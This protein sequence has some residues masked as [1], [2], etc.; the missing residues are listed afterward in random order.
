MQ[1]FFSLS[2]R[3]LSTINLSTSQLS[4]IVSRLINQSTYQPINFLLSSHDLSTSQLS[5]SD[6]FRK[7]APDHIQRAAGFEPLY[8]LLVESVV[9]F[10]LFLA[11]VF[12]VKHHSER[13]TRNE[14]SET[15]YVYAVIFLY[16]VVVC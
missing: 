14:C 7:R 3:D 10:E 4:F 12:V 6:F 11:A 2:S 13:G 1:V 8:L 9:H 15:Q 16:L 5:D